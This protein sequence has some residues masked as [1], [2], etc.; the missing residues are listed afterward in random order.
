MSSFRAQALA[1]KLAANRKAR[2][3]HLASLLKARRSS[4]VAENTSG[5]RRSARTTGVRATAFDSQHYGAEWSEVDIAPFF[6]V[7]KVRGK[8]ASGVLLAAD[9]VFD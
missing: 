8:N 1:A 5:S 4:S 7:V 3:A 9:V 2:S 6:G